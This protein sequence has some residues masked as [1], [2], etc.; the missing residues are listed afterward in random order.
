MENLLFLD[1]ILNM[2]KSPKVRFFIHL[3]ESIAVCDNYKNISLPEPGVAYLPEEYRLL[4]KS[5]CA[6]IAT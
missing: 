4:K 6:E 5:K 3:K 1:C 2:P